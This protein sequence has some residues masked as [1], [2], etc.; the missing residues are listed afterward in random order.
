M[1]VKPFFLKYR[2]RLPPMKPPAPVM[3]I[4]SSFCSSGSFSI[5]RFFSISHFHFN[6]VQSICRHLVFQIWLPILSGT[7]QCCNDDPCFT[8]DARS[9]DSGVLR[10][11]SRLQPVPKVAQASRL[12]LSAPPPED[13]S[14]NWKFD[15]GCLLA[16]YRSWMLDVGCFPFLLVLVL[17]LVLVL[18]F[19]FPMFEVLRSV[20]RLQPVPKVAQASRLSLSA[21]PPEDLSSNWK[22]DVGCWMLDVFPSFSS[23]FSSSIWG[24]E[25]GGWGCLLAR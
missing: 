21:P 22:F 16:I 8:G 19:P 11:V 20:S 24:L 15:V 13:L 9:R 10:S 4:K 25:S 23:S 5:S 2:A 14:S 17:I 18:E 1:R 6:L 3:T 7:S 12:S